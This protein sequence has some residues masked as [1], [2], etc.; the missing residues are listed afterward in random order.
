MASISH[1]LPDFSSFNPLLSNRESSNKTQ[2]SSAALQVRQSSDITLFTEEGDKVTLSSASRF[3]AGYAIYS[4]Q[5]V[6]DGKASQVDAEAFSVSKASV[7]ELSVE[8]DLNKQELK[9]IE[10]ALKTIEKLTTDFFSGNTDKAV[11]R[12]SR[13]AK[14]D[15]IASFEAVLQYSKSLSAK[16]AV[17]ETAP[18]QPEISPQTPPLDSFVA[19]PEALPLPEVLQQTKATHNAPPIP[20]PLSTAK[21]STEPSEQ[22]KP[23]LEEMSDAV[24]D[25]QVA[26][27]KIANQLDAFLDRLFVKLARGDRMDLQDLKLAK[28]IQLEFSSKMTEAAEAE[29]GEQTAEVENHKESHSES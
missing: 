4:S 27:S 11:D 5:G 13:I 25:S 6:I 9:D 29:A 18:A 15:S 20:G 1:Q 23:L 7:F 22:V 2:S 3:E 17:T 19:P 28:E 10:K 8:G 24:L 26:P 12:A 14:L 16:A 21:P